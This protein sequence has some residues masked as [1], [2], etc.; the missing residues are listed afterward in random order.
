[1]T[2][3]RSIGRACTTSVLAPLLFALALVGLPQDGRAQEGLVRIEG[4]V[5]DA[6][7]GQPLEQAH[8]FIASSMIG[9][10][11]DAEGRFALAKVPPGA[12]HLHISMVGY[13]PYGLDSLFRADATYTLDA[14]LKR[15]TIELQEI[16]VSAREA[17]RWQRRLIKFERLFLGETEKSAATTIINP[18]V[19]SFTSR[20]GKLSAVASAPIIIENR[21][22]GYR[23]QYYLKEFFYFGNTIKY[24]GDPLFSE[25]EPSSSDEAALWEENRCEAFFGSQRHYFLSL[26]EQRTE[27]EGFIT[28]RRYNLDRDGSAFPVDTH[29]LLR[30]GPT[31][32]EKEL[33]FTGFLEIVFT[34]ETEDQHF[35]RWQRVSPGGRLGDQR[36]FIELNRGPTL[37]DQAGEVID[38]YGITVYGYFAFERFG[39]LMPKEY[40]P[41][42]WTH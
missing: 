11:T 30:D 36:S 33:T 31:V 19:L 41:P 20:L 27:Q 13:A 17:R 18:E 12:H 34:G 16:T 10:T 28:Y 8:V 24:D 14:A 22:L 15:T 4:R 5:S 35:K 1:M 9:T 25:L 32:L 26:L 37:I 39:D 23:V 2:Y 6:E 38:P 40:R 29:K 7:T 42:G 3:P 21:A